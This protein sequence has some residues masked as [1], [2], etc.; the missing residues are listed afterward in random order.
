[1]L[2]LTDSV[3][4][5]YAAGIVIGLLQIPAFL[6]V[7]TALGASSSFVTAAAWIASVFDPAATQIDYFA[8]HMTSDK[9][10]WQSALVIGIALGAFVSARLGGVKRPSFARAWTELT[11]IK[12]LHGDLCDG[13]A[14]KDGR[15]EEDH[16]GTHHRRN[17][18]TH[19]QGYWRPRHRRGDRNDG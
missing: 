7:D 4:S 13:R 5:P 6:L 15:H 14:S 17:A 2:R 10:L 12:S 11:G 1:M 18:C 9:Y 3:W 19:P 8:K 16:L